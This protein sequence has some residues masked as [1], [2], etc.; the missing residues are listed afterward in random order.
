MKRFHKLIF[1]LSNSRRTLDIEVRR[2]WS[3]QIKNANGA[4]IRK[5]SFTNSRFSLLDHY[6]DAWLRTQNQSLLFWW[7]L[8]QLCSGFQRSS[9]SPVF[10]LDFSFTL[11]QPVN[12]ETVSCSVFHSDANQDINKLAE[13][14]IFFWG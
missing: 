3:E 6:G 14:A 4:P 10:K 8:L 1:G 12:Y 13:K 9:S 11:T 2:L 5:V 7:L